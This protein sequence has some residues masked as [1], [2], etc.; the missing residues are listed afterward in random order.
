[1]VIKQISKIVKFLVVISK[2]E[3]H[4]SVGEELAWVGGQRC[5]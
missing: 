4:V 1:M 3:K 5:L 2:A